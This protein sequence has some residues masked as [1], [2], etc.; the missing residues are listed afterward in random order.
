MVV[1]RCKCLELD[2]RGKNQEELVFSFWFM[3]ASR[4]NRSSL[5]FERSLEVTRWLMVVGWWL[6]SRD[7][8][9]ET[10][11]IGV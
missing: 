5:L 8:R 2:S 11:R 10:R 1:L 9:Q 7:K 3:V 4:Y 6:E